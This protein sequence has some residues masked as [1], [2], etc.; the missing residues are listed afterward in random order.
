MVPIYQAGGVC[1]R[2]S[3]N[4]EKSK[5]DHVFHEKS[6]GVPDRDGF[7]HLPFALPRDDTQPEVRK[8]IRRY[9]SEIHAG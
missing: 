1:G 6:D 5:R 7:L 4:H 3:I 2:S 8:L 9:E